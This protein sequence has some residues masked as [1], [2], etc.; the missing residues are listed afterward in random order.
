MH[1][2]PS[3]VKTPPQPASAGTQIP[4]VNPFVDQPTQGFPE[5]GPT[6]IDRFLS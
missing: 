3:A 6:S 2:G 4:R 5:L 1:N